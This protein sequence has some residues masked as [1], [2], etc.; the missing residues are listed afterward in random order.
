MD[1]SDNTQRTLAQPT[2]TAAAAHHFVAVQQTGFQVQ[3]FL[4][5]H[6]Q[7]LLGVRTGTQAASPGLDA[8]Q[9]VEYLGD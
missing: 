1:A 8:K 6:A 2:T 3:R 4:A 9:V 7:Q 5:R